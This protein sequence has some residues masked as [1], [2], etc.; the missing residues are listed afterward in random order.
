[1]EFTGEIA[2]IQQRLA[3]CHEMAA[4]RHAVLQHLGWGALTVR[5]EHAPYMMLGGRRRKS[6]FDSRLKLKPSH[7]RKC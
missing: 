7:R 3:A 4:R 1:M 6:G 5:G 2:T